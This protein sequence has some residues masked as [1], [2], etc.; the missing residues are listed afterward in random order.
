[1]ELER[2]YMGDSTRA[3]APE[4]L[5]R[6][7]STEASLIPTEFALHANYPNPFNPSTQIQ[8]D[9]PEPGNVSL[10][11]YDVLGREVAEIATGYYEPGY[12][13]APWNGN[14]GSGEP[15]AS[16]VYFARLAVSDASG[17]LR[18]SGVSKL[19]LMK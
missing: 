7:S 10:I 15:A 5:A 17:R 11:V 13:M 8:F 4:E 1:L 14:K 19:L 2:W 18:F 16:G 3:F 6:Q 12:H 9:L